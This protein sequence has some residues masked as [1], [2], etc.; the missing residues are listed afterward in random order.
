[1][2]GLVADLGPLRRHR[3]FRLIW[4]GQL[5]SGMGGQL[6]VVAVSYQVYRLTH[7][8]LDV[9]LVSLVQLGPLM[10]GSLAGGSVIDATD[11][12]RVLVVSQVCMALCSAGLGANAFLSR[13]RLWP[14]F[15]CT[16][17][18]ALFQ[19]TN[20]PARRAATTMVVPAS[21][22]T[23]AVA[24]QTMAVQ[25]AFV[26]GPALAGVLVS[27]AGL[28]TVYL[29]DVGSFC[30]SLFA[31]ALL[32]PLPPAGGGTRAGMRS[33]ADGFRYLR[34]QKLLAST[35]LIDLDAMIFGM[36]RAVFPAMATGFYHGGPGILGVLYA[37]PGI[38]GLVGSLLSG[39]VGRVRHQGRAVVIAVVGWGAA[40]ALFGVVRVL[41]LGVALLAVAGASDLVSAVFRSSIL[42]A[43]VPD[44]LQG[45]LAGVYFAVVAGGPRVGDVEAGIAARLGGPQFAVWS[46]GLACIAGVGLLLW[47]VPELWRARSDVEE[48]E[49]GPSL[50]AVE[51]VGQATA[52][53]S[54]SAPP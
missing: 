5:V 7:S 47:R 20:N 32:P 34:G 42:Q 18:S 52:E 8:T 9:G 10:A 17:A 23:G 2:G 25:W 26:V 6:T 36:P 40:V 53:L 13:P 1:M 41:W 51:A 24:L 16:A 28:G 22:L 49:A 43:S 44:H 48:R 54:E 45:R 33:L 30:M 35:F 3:A 38:G 4:T 37:A 50:A 15:V 11:R 29:I 46:G 19:G 21:D 27:A 39:W 31:T 14:L 12:R